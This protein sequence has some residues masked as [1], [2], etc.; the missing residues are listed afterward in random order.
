MK[1]RIDPRSKIAIAACL[2][3]LAVV[4]TT[5]AGLSLLCSVTLVLALV[6][7]VN[8]KQ[9]WQRFHKFLGMLLIIILLQSVCTRQGTPLI[10]I[11]GFPL[12]TDYGIHQGITFVL[13]MAIILMLGLLLATSS[14]RELTQGLIQLKLPYE[15]A[16]MATL[17]G[18]FLPILREEF[19]DS[20]H[21]FLLRGVDPKKLKLRDKVKIYTSIITPVCMN[22][23][24]K[25]KEISI[26]MELRGFRMKETRT[27]LFHLELGVKDYVII[28]SSI[29]F[30][31]LGLI[32]VIGGMHESIFGVW[33]YRFW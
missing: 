7:S 9:V 30:T 23:V 24:L 11:Y 18:K 33:H 12:L 19:V 14:N 13:R 28:I 4:W 32:G 31:L 26:A 16:F 1:Q 27:S 10:I 20:F 8:L 15:I 29:F 2:S 6:F 5:I 22:A 25:A 3:T 17:G 21:A